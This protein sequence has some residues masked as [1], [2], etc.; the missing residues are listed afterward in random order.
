MNGRWAV[1]FRAAVAVAGALALAACGESADSGAAAVSADTA[2]ASGT[3]TWW[4]TS[5]ATN[6]AP[7]FKELVDKFT[8]SHPKITVNYVNVPFAQAQEK[9]RTAAQAGAGAPDV[10]RSEVA[11]TSDFASL[12]YLADLTG[13]VETADFLPTPLSSAQLDGKLYGLPQVTDAP[14]L[15]YNKALLQKAGVAVPT[16]WAELG[17]AAPKLTAAVPGLRAPLFLQSGGYFS[18][19]FLYS[20]GGDL[21]DT[22]QRRI[23]VNSPE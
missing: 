17:A 4:D 22:A 19:P 14:A 21:L 6:E 11:W 5:D 18:L 16:T 9:F 23:L 10:L 8:T 20:E 7:V 13:K 12:G 15:L 1:R 3:V 2:D